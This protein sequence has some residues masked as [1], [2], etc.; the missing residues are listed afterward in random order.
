MGSNTFVTS[1][2]ENLQIRNGKSSPLR[3]EDGEYPVYGSNGIIGYSNEYNSE[4]NTI[5][6]GRVGSYCGSVYISEKKCWVTDNA[7]I[8]TAKNKN[9]SSYWFYLLKNIDLNNY[10]VGSGQPL[11]NQT[12][13][14]TISVSIPKLSEKR[15]LIG[16]FIFLFDQKISLFWGIN[17]TLEQ[18]SQ[19]LFKSWFV[20]FDPV[21]DNALDAGKLIPEA[22]QSR[23][24]LRQKVRNSAD[25][26]PL[27]ADIRALFPNEFEETELSWVPKG[28]KISTADDELVVKGGS[29]P[30][31]SNEE[32]W[33]NGTIH[34]TSP[35]DLTGNDSKILLDTS[36]KITTLGLEKIASGLLPID[37]V[38]MS[39]RAPIGY[40]A[41]VKTPMAINQGY[42]AIPSSR[43]LSP[44]YI[45]YWLENIMDDIKGMA[46]GTTFAEISKTTFK[47]ISLVIPSK[48]TV[49]EFTRLTHQHFEK[50]VSNTKQITA[51]TALRDTLLPK[52]ISGELSLEDLPDLI[53]DTEAA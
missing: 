36:K 17:Q 2:G 30:S 53:E 51:L 13:I 35:K 15:R 48:D 39:S 42:I 34:W 14:N 26:K 46:G 7:I 41:L 43:N 20:D 25:F 40:L 29:T 4:E 8:A 6:I 49:D 52:L 5:I 19:T 23:A 31:T 24:E 32:F 44:E 33:E 45:I 37:T 28:W 50:I 9:E 12:I 21:I 1:I 27:P 16:D 38:L 22:L 3:T 10:R 11:I 47:T 18:M